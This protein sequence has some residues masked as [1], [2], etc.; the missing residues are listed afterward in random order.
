[1]PLARLRARGELMEI[2]AAELRFQ[3]EETAAYLNE[4]MDLR[5]AS[6]DI[7]LL[8]DRTEGWITA[9]RLLSDRPSVSSIC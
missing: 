2:R 4:V 3:Q 6:P 1:L 5:L 9:L 8:E 7:E